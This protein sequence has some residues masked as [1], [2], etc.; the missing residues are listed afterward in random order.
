M[1]A[2]ATIIASPDATDSSV[3]RNVAVTAQV[4][5]NLGN[6]VAGQAVTWTSGGFGHIV[7]S[8][9]ATNVVGTVRAIVH[10]DSVGQS[11]ITAWIGAADRSGSCADNGGAACSDITIN[12]S[13]DVNQC[14]GSAY[15]VE[16]TPTATRV[17]EVTSNPAACGFGND[18]DQ[19]A[20]DVMGIK[21]LN[22]RRTVNAF[23]V[24]AEASTLEVP[25]GTFPAQV[26]VDVFH[27]EAAY[28]CFGDEADSLTLNSGRV[29][30]R[31]A[32]GDVLYDDV[33]APNTTQ[34]LAGLGTVILNEQ[35]E[36]VDGNH[37]EGSVNA[38]H[39]VA[40]SDAV[41]VV[42]AHAQAAITCTESHF[43]TVL[44]VH[45]D[46]HTDYSTG[47]AHLRLDVYGTDEAGGVP[48]I[49][50]DPLQYSD[51]R[52]DPPGS[53]AVAPFTCFDGVADTLAATSTHAAHLTGTITCTNFPSAP[54]PGGT[55]LGQPAGSFSFSLDVTDSAV[56]CPGTPDHY[57]I[58]L[59]DTTTN[60]LL[61]SWD[62]DTDDGCLTVGQ[63][64]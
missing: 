21:A 45:G 16:L 46:A 7:V 35:T 9:P 47:P 4:A 8:D 56:T 20:A 29:R 14:D 43:D 1:A 41:G 48:P 39:V 31:D 38:L 34:S 26:I 52:A 57:A 22:A 53:N 27:A 23:R 49:T 19:T 54:Q 18:D 64:S 63:E 42:V 59:R 30:V 32:F 2:T 13:Q 5:D 40:L 55:V 25:L 62:D 12:W 60:A 37:A 36:V 6:P 61:Y 17:S 3:G 15:A 24:T 51:S 33:P 50:I 11:V 44:R 58:E 10:G 28:A